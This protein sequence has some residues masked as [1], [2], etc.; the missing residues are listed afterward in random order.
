MA[1][2]EKANVKNQYTMFSMS[3]P[4]YYFPEVEEA[5]NDY[6]KTISDLGEL[7]IKKD[8]IINSQNDEINRL[9]NELGE[10]HIQLNAIDVPDITDEEAIEVLSDFKEEVTKVNSGNVKKHENN[11]NTKKKIS[12]IG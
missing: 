8:S 9:Q 2:K 10:L 7:L 6:K 11:N 4:G 12:I 1:K 5:I 3:Q